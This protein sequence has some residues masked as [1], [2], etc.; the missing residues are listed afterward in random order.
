MV[1]AA[2]MWLEQAAAELGIPVTGGAGVVLQVR[3]GAIVAATRAAEV[4]LGLTRDQLLGRTSGDP[5][6]V[7]VD[8]NGRP[9]AADDHP[10]MRVLRR[11]TPVMDSVMGIHR[12][13]EDA[14]GEHVWLLVRS[15][16]SSLTVAGSTPPSALTVF[17]PLGPRESEDLRLRDSERKYRL[18]AESSSDMVTWQALDSTF[19]WVSPA[20]RAVLGYVPDEL[21]GTPALDLVHPD[22]MPLVDAMRRAAE[23]DGD[24]PPGSVTMRFRHADGSWRW[25][26]STARLLRDRQGVLS[27]LSTSGRDVTARIRTE[28]ERDEAVEMFRLAMILAPVGMA[29]LGGG[30]RI[31]QVNRALCEL[32]GRP[33]ADLLGR[34]GA[35]VLAG[36][37]GPPLL[38]ADPTDG[39]D[40]VSEAEVRFC[41]PDGSDLWCRR[42]LVPLH[43]ATPAGVRGRVLV[44]VQDV[45]V[46]RTERERLAAAARTDVLTGLPNRAVL[47]D[48]L[49]RALGGRSPDPVGVLFVDLDGFKAVNDTWGHDAGDELLR[50]IAARLSVTVRAVDLVVRLGGDEFVVLCEDVGTTAE[51]DALARRIRAAIREPVVVDGHVLTVMASVGVTAGKDVSARDLLVRADRAMYSAKRAGRT[52]PV[53]DAVD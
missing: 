32:L 51:L 40:R 36:P 45:T 18:L 46:E 48:R 14:A 44:Q 35:D 16:P 39:V 9:L 17:R 27:G 19:L 4:V 20:S 47:L 29:L 34:A 2:D 12:P 33:E 50:Q 28:R 23:Q 53:M 3:S 38:T 26:E 25:I 52:R 22:D 37:A 1:D 5:R 8:R 42:S 7:A 13:A 31:E 21:I 11:G 43:G 10:P 30:G 24:L 6:W 49:N 41:R 15:V